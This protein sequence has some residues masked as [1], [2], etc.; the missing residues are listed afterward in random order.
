MGNSPQTGSDKV[1]LT[2]FTKQDFITGMKSKQFKKVVF[3]TGAGISVAAGIPDFRSPGSGLYSKVEELKLPY[4]EALFSIDYFSENPE[5]FYHFAKIFIDTLKAKPV[6]A[7]HFIKMFD[8]EKLLQLSCTQNV[9]GLELI[10]GV[11]PKKLLEAHGHLRSAA[12]IKCK[13]V[14]KIEEF[15]EA[16]AKQT[17]LKCDCG[18]LVK[19]D[20]VFFGEALPPEFFLHMKTIQEADLVIV[21]GTSLK[22][23]PFA[24]LIEVVPTEVPIVLINRENSLG[25]RERVLYL[26]G[27][28]EETVK[29][30]LKDLEWE[31][32][33]P[34]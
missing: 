13:S 4:P 29:G 15:K 32:K 9:D 23:H 34:Q 21:M 33:I 19:P 16:I 20:I 26:G 1:G 25:E 22:V 28:I 18:G 6:L 31:T 17:V 3:L 8:D 24:G 12:C 11:D 5:A 7:H 10:A 14:R 30:L 2:P 27:D